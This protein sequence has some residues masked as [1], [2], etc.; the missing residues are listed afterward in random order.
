MDDSV[1]NTL[2]A[3]VAMCNM[4]SS[5]EMHWN[6]ETNNR[7]GLQLYTQKYQP[8]FERCAYVQKTLDD[9]QALRYAAAQQAQINADKARLQNGLD[10]IRGAPFKPED[11]PSLQLM[12]AYDCINPV[13]FTN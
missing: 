6:S 11:A 10:A 3:V 1:F 7:N 5:S 9:E 4:H 13:T 2:L 8:G 12:N